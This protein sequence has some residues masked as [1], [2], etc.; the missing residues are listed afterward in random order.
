MN[1][2]STT[3]TYRTQLT[4]LIRQEIEAANGNI[5]FARFMQ[6]ALY[7]PK[8]GYYSRTDARIGKKGDFLTAPEIS[9]LFAK[10]IAKQCVE[11]F[12]IMDSRHFLEIGAGSGVFARDLL[13]E[14][15]RLNSLPDIYYILEISEELKEQQKQLLQ[16]EC[17]HLLHRIVWLEKLP[18]HFKG[19]I[20]ANEVMDAFPVH[21]FHIN[22]QI[23][24]KCV[25]WQNDQFFW[26][27]IAAEKYLADKLL[28]LK[29]AMLLSDNY[30][31]EICLQLPAWIKSL[32]DTLDQG[33]ILLFDYGYGSR[34]Y[35]HP[36]RNRGTLMCYYQQQR[37]DNPFVNIGAQ[38]IT[39]H[40][41]FTLAA[42]A[43]VEA[44]LN[45]IGYTTQASFLLATGI[46][47]FP[48][49]SIEDKSAIKKLMLPSQMGEAIKVLGLSKNMDLSLSGF[50]LFDRRKDL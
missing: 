22:G 25:T 44:G 43:A 39:A 10:T 12:S 17:G 37:H 16:K 28:E 9:P 33:V 3:I 19:I 5:N 11:I 15:E 50:K 23:F 6:L 46:L 45:V 30:E 34:E 32:S 40:V 27:P 14:M 29:D 31:S 35:Y 13:V 47:D 48:G 21:C 8:L 4:D 1:E 18:A 7:T 2:V 26:L 41:D 20:F 36:D 38:D 42:T 49:L 24:E